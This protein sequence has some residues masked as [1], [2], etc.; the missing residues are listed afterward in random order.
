[1]RPDP[2]INLAK[3]NPPALP[4]KPTPLNYF[5]PTPELPADR[6]KR[7]SS[8]ISLLG[9]LL[10]IGW[11]LIITYCFYIYDPN[12]GK[13]TLPAQ[14]FIWLTCTGMLVVFSEP[15]QRDSKSHALWCGFTAISIVQFGLYAMVVIANI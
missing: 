8:V 5:S 3:Q 6:L 12:F 2:K 4:Q 14:F 11:T 9:I 15:L 1:M 10:G 7:D 13:W